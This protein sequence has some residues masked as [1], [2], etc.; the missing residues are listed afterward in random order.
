MNNDVILA[1]NGLL[2]GK[3]DTN[4]MNTAEDSVLL[5]TL[6]KVN[7]IVKISFKVDT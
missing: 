6:K 3:F 1:Q 7:N 2:S 4:F 5:E